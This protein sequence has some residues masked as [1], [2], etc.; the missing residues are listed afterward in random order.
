MYEIA[1]VPRESPFWPALV[2]D[3]GKPL[4]SRLAKRNTQQ[5]ASDSAPDL[6]I[7]LAD[8]TGTE[9]P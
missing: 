6:D 4:E 7:E 5:P 9:T 1:W 3:L 8:E 2:I